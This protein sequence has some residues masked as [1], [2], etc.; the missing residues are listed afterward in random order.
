MCGIAGILGKE[1]GGIPSEERLSRALQRLE[2]R[3]PDGEG[4]WSGRGIVLGMRRLSIIDLAGG[5]QPFFSEGRDIVGVVNGEIYNAPELRAALETKGHRFQGGSDCEVLVHLYEEQ[6][7]EFMQKARG[8]FAVSLWDVT[9]Q[10]LILAVDRFGEKPLYVAEGDGNLCWASELRVIPV[11]TGK[12]LALAPEALRTDL[13]LTYLP[14]PRTP[15]Q[16][17][18][19]L[20]PG[21]IE[22]WNQKKWES[23]RRIYWELERS[24]QNKTC[25]GVEGLAERLEESSRM[26]LRSDRS[27][28]VALSGGLDSSLVATLAVRGKKNIEAFTVGYPGEPENDERPAARDLA[29]SLGIS[30]HECEISEEEVADEFPK[31][32]ELMDE[33]VAD[34]AAPGYLRIFREAAAKKIPVLLMGQGG[35]ELFLGYEWVRRAV[36]HAERRERREKQPYLAWR[37]YL[38]SE[39]GA[40]PRWRKQCQSAWEQFRWWKRDGS[41]ES[42]GERML[43][44]NPEM[45][46]VRRLEGKLF[47][48]AFLRKSMSWPQQEDWLISAGVRSDL[49]I[50]GLISRIYL[51]GNGLTLADRLGM[52]YSVEARLPMLDV[53]WVE[54]VMACQ[55]ESPSHVLD[56]KAR[57]KEV[58]EYLGLPHEIIH[59]PK[60]GFAPPARQWK[61]KILQRYLP[62]LKDGILMEN[63]ILSPQGW[64]LL[65]RKHLEGARYTNAAYNLLVVEGFL[66][67]FATDL[68]VV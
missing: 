10:R 63:G 60:R 21:S 24:G 65:E 56:P 15:F 39:K 49:D 25:P 29:R 12:K 36:R 7:E 26:T 9:R 16:G 27:V 42:W 51:A 37:E 53:D 2:H 61:R 52:A 54:A 28:G 66:R 14:A 41:G 23:T 11:L 5:Q 1:S 45:E 44:L 59:R 13:R 18:R 50:I 46:E 57:L 4:R 48:A 32:L 40:D 35:D 19:K 3:G 47:T 68:E 20:R 30:L 43:A 8:M 17:V 31:L 34:I 62:W 6:G 38:G 22:I 33:P 64:K 67:R 58:A 55:R